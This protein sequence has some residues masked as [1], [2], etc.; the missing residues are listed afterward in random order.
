MHEQDGAGIVIEG[1]AE[2]SH[3]VLE[4]F[5]NA[6][7]PRV[8]ALCFGGVVTGGVGSLCF[9]ELGRLL[10]FDVGSAFFGKPGAVFADV[11]GPRLHEI[12]LDHIRKIEVGLV[13][14]G[15]LDA[16]GAERALP[17]HARIAAAQ[18][19]GSGLEDQRAAEVFKPTGRSRRKSR[20]TRAN[21]HVVGFGLPSPL[22]LLLLLGRLLL[23][24]SEHS[25][26]RPCSDGGR[27][28]LQKPSTSQTIRHAVLLLPS[29]AS[30]PLRRSACLLRC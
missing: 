14:D 8:V 6:T 13:F 27:S 15:A 4:G 16:R 17:A 1:R 20:R 23:R 26:S 19:F 28:P 18:I 30:S 29:V 24:A 21:D 25:H 9:R 22:V 12:F 2:R 10:E 3:R 11:L 7:A 5:P